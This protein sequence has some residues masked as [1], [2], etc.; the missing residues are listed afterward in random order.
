LFKFFKGVKKDPWL[1]KNLDF[2]E[3][4]NLQRVKENEIMMPHPLKENL[5]VGC[6]TECH[7]KILGFYQSTKNKINHEY[8]FSQK[9]K[10][11]AITLYEDKFL[12]IFVSDFRRIVKY[13]Q[14]MINKDV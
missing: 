10:I 3:K 6:V 14:Q 4:R 2:G 11:H 13:P 7:L 9:Q 8:S 12:R 1:R 5:G